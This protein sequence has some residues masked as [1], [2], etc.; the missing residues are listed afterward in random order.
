MS[1]IS[2]F[3][4]PHSPRTSSFYSFQASPQFHAFINAQEKEDSVKRQMM[5]CPFHLEDMLED[6]LELSGQEKFGLGRRAFAKAKHQKKMKKGKNTF[7]WY[8]NA[9]KRKRVAGSSP[10]KESKKVGNWDRR[11]VG[12]QLANGTGNLVTIDRHVYLVTD[13]TTLYLGVGPAPSEPVA[14]N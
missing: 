14:K 2:N 1:T 6:D 11:E 10:E 8:P 7:A 12:E 9:N 5:L 3:S 13:K 4:F